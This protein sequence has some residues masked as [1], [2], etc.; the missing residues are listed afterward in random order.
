MT[1]SPGCQL[2]SRTCYWRKPAFCLTSEPS[3]HRSGPGAIDRRRLGWRVRWTPFRE[4]QVCLRKGCWDTVL[5]PPAGT[6]HC[7]G[8]GSVGLTRAH[9]EPHRPARARQV[10]LAGVIFPPRE[11]LNGSNPVASVWVWLMHTANESH[12]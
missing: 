12:G 9:E 4:Q 8:R 3:T 7:S 6:G 1:P 10:S 11:L 2:A 5:A